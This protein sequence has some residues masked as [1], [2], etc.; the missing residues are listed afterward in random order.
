MA[1]TRFPDLAPNSLQDL[2]I[3]GSTVTDAIGYALF[4]LAIFGIIMLRMR[5]NIVN[6]FIAA[7]LI[8]FT[9]ALFFFAGGLVTWKILAM[10][11]A[12]MM[13]SFLTAL[14]VKFK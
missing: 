1:L 9:F 13:I 3:Y 4:L 12:M 14:F 5:L 6:G 11:V 2:F 8:T 7:T 10:S